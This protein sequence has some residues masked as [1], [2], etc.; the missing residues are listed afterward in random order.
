MNVY[1]T[2]AYLAGYYADGPSY[3]GH[4]AAMAFVKALKGSEVKI[5]RKFAG[6]QMSHNHRDNAFMAFAEW[7]GGLLREIGEPMHLVPVPGSKLHVGVSSDQNTSVAYR[8]A[9]ACATSTLAGR[10]T[11]I[12][13]LRFHTP[14]LSA[15]AEKNEDA[16][17]PAWLFEQLRVVAPLPN[18]G[19]IVLVDDV[20]TTGAHLTAC[21]NKLR[22]LRPGREPIGICAAKTVKR[23]VD[24]PYP[25]P[26]VT[27]I[28]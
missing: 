12:D 17:N 1:F 27:S 18:S 8:M 9:C 25:Y 5:P 23:Y 10:A 6:R 14:H 7:A 4:M 21:R 19:V 26:E 13:A 22:S 28:A 16:R 11:V 3:E 15:H 2:S 20:F 24:Q